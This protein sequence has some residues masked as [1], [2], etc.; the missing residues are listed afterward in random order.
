M[1]VPLG[2][3]AEPLGR[4]LREAALRTAAGSV[5]AAPDGGSDLVTEA[6][7]DGLPAPAQRYL[8]AMGVVGRPRDWSF[9]VRMSG[10]FRR[11]GQAWMPCAA[12]QY[13]ANHPITR[14]FHM[15]ID[16]AHVVPMVGR[17]T[18]LD[19]HGAMHGKVLGLVPVVDGSGPEFDLGELVTY[20][21]DALV[22]APSMLL[23]EAV[24]W[25]A[26][27]AE[28]FAVHLADRGNTVRAEVR[29]GP[30]GL[31]QDFSTDD[32]WYDGPD[33][34]VRARWRTPFQGWTH[35]DGRPWLTSAQAVW[36]LP[37]GPL[38]YIE[39]SF[40]AG[41]VTR[42]V[43]PGA[44]LGAAA[45]RSTRPRLRSSSRPG[46]GAPGVAGPI[47]RASANDMM[48]LATEA[49]SVP[50]QVGAIL[51]LRAGVGPDQAREV[52]ARRVPAIPR[53]RQRLAWPRPGGGRPVWVDDETFDIDDHLHVRPCPAP[54]D[55]SAL[56]ACATEILGERLA[57][58]R[59]LWG[60]TIVTGLAEDRWALVIVFNH[61][62]ADGIGGLA[63]LI[64]LVDGA[65]DPQDYGFPRPSPS[66]R[67]LTL[68]ATR[69]RL[70]ALA[71]WR[72][73][74]A[75]VRSAAVELS[76]DLRSSRAAHLAQPAHRGEAGHAAPCGSTS[77]PCGP[78]PMPTAQPSTTSC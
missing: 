10:R 39:A 77:T 57:E 53:L 32:R 24:T 48:E 43:A 47:E 31:M 58:G 25:E 8:R 73:W 4:D 37:D 12:W 70:G 51:V 21:N 69:Q 3:L 61:V 54:G 16:A 38:P 14:A 41:S 55:E 1:H 64:G 76:P 67:E 63:A 71:G 11:P 7:L 28:T 33:G 75:R 34:L 78:P 74:L 59:P 52:L 19:G 40:V 6:D 50:M 68:D 35:L 18:Y 56:L 20:L 72:S 36:D 2:P 13:N 66:G 9:L 17:D 65:P 46:V 15:R 44:L 29:V 26:V 23:D 42:N 5:V 60:A 45:H 27:D 30:D 62:L 22:L 49:G